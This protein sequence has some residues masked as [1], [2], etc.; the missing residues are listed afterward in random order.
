MTVLK[1]SFAWRLITAWLFASTKNSLDLLQ[2]P[3]RVYKK[4]RVVP[5][6]ALQGQSDMLELQDA[7]ANICKHGEYIKMGR[8]EKHTR[9]DWPCLH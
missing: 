9:M 5:V 3:W 4:G 8:L 6:F 7:K 1:P 2:S